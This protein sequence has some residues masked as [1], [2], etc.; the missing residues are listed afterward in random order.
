MAKV[1]A[2]N[3][4]YSGISASVPF[5]NGVGECDTPHILDWFRIHGYTVV[6]D[7]KAEPA[8]EAIE[9][10]AEAEVLEEVVELAD[11][12]PNYEEMTKAQLQEIADD[13]SIPYNSHT[14]KEQL[15]SALKGE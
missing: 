8:E 3:K 5:V 6:E 15:V 13:R 9:L 12:K 7:G 4:N 2:P 1:Y 10:E 11:D 14:T